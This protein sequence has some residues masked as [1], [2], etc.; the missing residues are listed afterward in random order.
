MKFLWILKPTR[1]PRFTLEEG[2]AMFQASRKWL[3]EG[4]KDGTHECC[5]AFPDGGSVTIINVASPEA[6]FALRNEFPG[7]ALFDHEIMALAD[8]NQAQDAV[9]SRMKKAIERRKQAGT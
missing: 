3:D 8:V 6:A 7:M 2:L 5:Y 4:L 9:I 1:T